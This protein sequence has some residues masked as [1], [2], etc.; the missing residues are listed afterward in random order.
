[1]SFTLYEWTYVIHVMIIWISERWKLVYK[2]TWQRRRWADFGWWAGDSA[3]EIDDRA[4]LIGCH[5]S[6]ASR[7]MN[8]LSDSTYIP[9]WSSLTP[10]TRRVRW[11]ERS[12]CQWLALHTE[13]GGQ[14]QLEGEKKQNKWSLKLSACKKYFKKSCHKQESFSCALAAFTLHFPPIYFA[15]NF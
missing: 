14:L 6:P 15:L 7:S 9:S 2:T 1:M 4:V 3:T 10:G 12:Y 5:S 13:T 8:V 11:W